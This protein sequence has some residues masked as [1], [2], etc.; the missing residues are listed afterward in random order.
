[1]VNPPPK[2]GCRLYLPAPPR[3]E[4]S[5][6]VASTCRAAPRRSST[7]DRMAVRYDSYAAAGHVCRRLSL[8]GRSIY[9]H[10]TS[11]KRGSKCLSSR[12]H[13][14]ATTL[15]LFFVHITPQIVCFRFTPADL[16]QDILT[17]YRYVQVWISVFFYCWPPKTTLPHCGWHT[18]SFL[19]ID[20]VLH[21]LCIFVFSSYYDMCLVCGL[22]RF[23]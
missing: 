5:P 15:A 8:Y 14:A 17:R 19:C 22:G 12:R 18:C 20:L 3:P 7:T 21:V 11:A 16:G 1:M 9:P 6:A 10:C 13:E 23:G 2:T 4:V